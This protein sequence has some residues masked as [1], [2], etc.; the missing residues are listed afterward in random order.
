MINVEDIEAINRSL[1]PDAIRAKEQ[2]RRIIAKLKRNP[3]ARSSITHDIAMSRAP[4]VY[5]PN[6]WA[7]DL[8]RY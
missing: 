3:A 2:I 5:T 1:N 6:D 8:W 7:N 4:V